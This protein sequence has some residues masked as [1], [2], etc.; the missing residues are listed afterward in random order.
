[1]NI[2]NLSKEFLDIFDELEENG[3]ELTEEL[4]KRLTITQES[5]KTSVKNLSSVVKQ[6][7]YECDAIK[8]E[9]KR[10][11]ELYDRKQK[12]IERIKK[13]LLDA[14]NN[15]GDTKK[16]GVKYVAWE[17]GECSIRKSQAVEV[18]NNLLT[19]IEVIIEDTI[20]ENKENNQLDVYDRISLQDISLIADSKPFSDYCEIE[21]LNHMN[22]GLSLSV[23]MSELG[24]GNAYVLL[25][26]IAKYTDDFKLSVG[27]SKTELKKDLEVNGA[28][29]PNLAKLVI[30]ENIQIK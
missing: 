7:D 11:K 30:N 27:A 23:P 12:V 10:L 2:Y 22:V 3:G 26:E 1:M 13:I 9:Q 19:T 28:C 6:L 5:F 8:E 24:N 4:E 15:F 14:I 20:K 16:T 21:D 18:N 29:A 17:T 25:K